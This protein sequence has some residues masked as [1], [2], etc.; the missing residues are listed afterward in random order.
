MVWFVYIFNFH[1]FVASNNIIYQRK[2][3]NNEKYIYLNAC[4]RGDDFYRLW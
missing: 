2:I 3:H 4:P 1:I